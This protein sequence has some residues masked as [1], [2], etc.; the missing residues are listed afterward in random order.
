M[1]TLI[2]LYLK[3]KMYLSLNARK[4]KFPSFSKIH[5]STLCLLQECTLPFLSLEMHLTRS[6]SIVKILTKTHTFSHRCAIGR[7]ERITHKKVDITKSRSQLVWVV[8]TD[9]GTHFRFL[10][11]CPVYKKWQNVK[12]CHFF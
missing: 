12:I 3:P 6:K 7:G 10:A 2:H 1:L 4:K 9:R 11:I 8:S 5:I